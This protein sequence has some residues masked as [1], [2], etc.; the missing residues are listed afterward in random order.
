MYLCVAKDILCDVQYLVP[1]RCCKYY[2]TI[3]SSV[4][5]ALFLHVMNFFSILLRILLENISEELNL[6]ETGKWNRGI[7]P[8]VLGVRLNDLPRNFEL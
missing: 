7:S 2:N 6:L 1:S 3:R 5:T 8:S 4:D